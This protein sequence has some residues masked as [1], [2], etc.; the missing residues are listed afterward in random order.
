[1]I[2]NPSTSTQQAKS[3]NHGIGY[4]LLCNAQNWFSYNL[5][6]PS[7]LCNE[8]NR[9]CFCNLDVHCTLGCIMRWGITKDGSAALAL[10]LCACTGN[11]WQLC[12]LLLLAS[13]HGPCL[14][15]LALVLI[16]AAVAGALASKCLHHM[17]NQLLQLLTSGF[18]IAHVHC[19]T[20]DARKWTF[21]SQNRVFNCN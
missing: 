20:L 15:L 10:T 11:L 12:V 18:A 13:T 7:A 14:C 3:R 16:K 6:Q 8:Q 17:A 19:A 4:G 2:Y 1:M 21:Y 5:L 9:I